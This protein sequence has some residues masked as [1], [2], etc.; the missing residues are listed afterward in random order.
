[1]NTSAPIE[2]LFDRAM[3]SLRGML[4]LLDAEQ[5]AVATRD[6]QALIK[7]SREKASRLQVFGEL[8]NLLRRQSLPSHLPLQ[9]FEFL[10]SRCAAQ[11]KANGMQ[12]NLHLAQQPTALPG[13]LSEGYGAR[14]E[15]RYGGLSTSL[16]SV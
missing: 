2:T 1:M 10:L 16:V 9:D 7:L 12:M 5:H 4:D 15:T 14:G 13:V 11:N 8:Q 6:A 3:Q